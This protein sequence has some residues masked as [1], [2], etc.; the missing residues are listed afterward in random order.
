MCEIC[1][2]PSQ[3]NVCEGCQDW[4]NW[5]GAIAEFRDREGGK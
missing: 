4:L 1:E 5:L 3:S 2:Q